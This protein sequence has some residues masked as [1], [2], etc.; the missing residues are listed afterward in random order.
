MVYVPTK[1]KMAVQ[2]TYI[3]ITGRNITYDQHSKYDQD[4]IACI[5]SVDK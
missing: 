5:N 1:S 4:D 2:G 3:Y